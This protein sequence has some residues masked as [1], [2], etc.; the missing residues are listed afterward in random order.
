MV[1]R[2]I[3]LFVGFLPVLWIAG[4]GQEEVTG[5][6]LVRPVRAIKVADGGALMDRSF[7]GRAKATQEV[8]ASFRVSGPLI[9]LPADLVGRTFTQ[10]EL[11]ARIDPRDYEVDLDNSKGQLGRAEATYKRATSDYERER[12]IYKLD[13]GATS[14]TAVENK[15]ANKDK[16]AADVQA[17]QASVAAAEDRLKYTYLYAPFDG[18][19]VKQYVQNFE[20][21]VAQQAILRIV[22]NSRIEMVVNIPETLISSVPYVENIRV[23]F[24]AFPDLEVPATIKEVGKE[25]SRTT[26]TYPVTLIMEQPEGVRIL[27]GMAGR[28][29]ADNRAPDALA[30]SGIRV[31]VSAI[32]SPQETDQSFVWVVD[33]GTMTVRRRA[34]TVGALADSGVP[35]DEGLEPGE[36][37]VIAGVSY[38][39]EGQQVKFLDDGEG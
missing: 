23:R 25:A 12:R 20:H 36:W 24:D 18:T 6:D 29:T 32:H 38:L 35:V 7:P 27:P 4:C 21:V 28:S 16:A 30:A 19:V 33:P 14:E 2:I 3:L 13:P 10:G 26:R 8:D 34:V 17:L 9:V 37:V 31:P 22:D 5:K 11:I 1:S 15:L 39:R